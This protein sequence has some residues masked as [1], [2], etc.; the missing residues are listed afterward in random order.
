MRLVGKRSWETELR[1]GDKVT[2][3]ALNP[4][5]SVLEGSEDVEKRW[6][7]V[8]MEAGVARMWPHAENAGR[9][10]EPE[11][12]GRMLPAEPPVRAWSRQHARA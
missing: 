4:L 10:Q 5:P 9:H 11:E 2:Q 6:S 8:Q 3:E 12:A 1:S 7:R